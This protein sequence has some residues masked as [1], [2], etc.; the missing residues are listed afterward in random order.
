MS[1]FFAAPPPNLSNRFFRQ[2]LNGAQK[3][4]FLSYKRDKILEH[5]NWS[6]FLLRTSRMHQAFLNEADRQRTLAVESTS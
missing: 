1:L 3:T 6:S 2:A 4:A 5:L